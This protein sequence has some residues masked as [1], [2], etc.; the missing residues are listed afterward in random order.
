MHF[1]FCV[2]K[3][4][5]YLIQIFAITEAGIAGYWTKPSPGKPAV[6]KY[7]GLC[8]SRSTSG[9]VSCWWPGERGGRQPVCL[10]SWLL[11]EAPWFW[12]HLGPVLAVEAI[13]KWTSRWEMPLS[14]FLPLCNSDFKLNRS[15]KIAFKK[16]KKEVSN[17]CTLSF[18][19]FNILF[20]S[21]VLLSNH[22][23]IMKKERNL[24]KL[25]NYLH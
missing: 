18:S 25:C 21:A 15:L 6:L 24:C 23:I 3:V 5:E 14:L 12:I 1:L 19:I 20:H 16:L 4:T 22:L 10:G 11:D 9:P 17:Q 13:W 2:Y 7:S 8:L